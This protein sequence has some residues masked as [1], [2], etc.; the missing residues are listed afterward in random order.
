MT[1]N[2]I[3]WMSDEHFVLTNEG[4][5]HTGGADQGLL[6]QFW[7]YMKAMAMIYGD[8]NADKLKQNKLEK[9]FKK[10]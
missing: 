8:G 4:W 10:T 5:K 1:L 3:D 6:E 9:Y 7:F 2:N